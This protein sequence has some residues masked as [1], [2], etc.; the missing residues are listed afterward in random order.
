[1]RRCD[2]CGENLDY[3][4]YCDYNGEKSRCQDVFAKE[5]RIIIPQVYWYEAVIVV[6]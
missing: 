6:K 1:M 5:W 2:F 4:I 3:L